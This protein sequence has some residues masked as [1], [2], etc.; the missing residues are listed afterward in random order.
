MTKTHGSD[1]R[2]SLVIPCFNEALNA[3]L[4]I[5]SIADA[6]C[7]TDFEFEVI[8]VDGGSTDNTVANLH[9]QIEQRGLADTIRVLERP[10]RS[11][12]GADICAGLKAS[13]GEVL[14]WTHADMQTDITDVVRAYREFRRVSE[15]QT[16]IFVKGRRRARPFVDTFF[17]F[18]MQVFTLLVARR[19]LVDINAQPKLFDR[20]FLEKH[21]LIAPPDDFSLDLHAYY[22]AAEL[23]YVIH[24]LPVTYKERKFGEAKGGGGGLSLK[25]ALARR[26]ISYIR[27]FAKKTRIL[28]NSNVQQ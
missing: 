7:D 9:D 11:G 15:S 14:A 3:E 21:L 25:L 2:L 10:F 20:D 16:K 27:A 4:L 24:T 23:G 12:Y 6:A 13:K 5:R 17:T 22:L 1:P 26:T 28:E 19:N 18:A 8:I